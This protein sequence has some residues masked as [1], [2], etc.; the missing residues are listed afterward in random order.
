MSPSLVFVVATRRLHHPLDADGIPI[1]YGIIIQVVVEQVVEPYASS[2][3][4]GMPGEKITIHLV[5]S[6]IIN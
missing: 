4:V 2:E 1:K 5:F 3:G 6:R